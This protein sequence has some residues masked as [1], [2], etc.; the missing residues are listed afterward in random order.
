[1]IQKLQ[2]SFNGYGVVFRMWHDNDK[3]KKLN[4]TSLMGP[5]KLKLLKLL[6]DKLYDCQPDDMA[7]DVADLWKV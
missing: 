3:D 5:D 6:P 4:W 2:T 7:S 1:M